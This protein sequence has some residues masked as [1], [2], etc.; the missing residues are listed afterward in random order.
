MHGHVAASVCA[1]ACVRAYSDKFQEALAKCQSLGMNLAVP[2]TIAEQ[3]FLVNSHALNL[4]SYDPRIWVG[5][6]DAET[7]GEL[8]M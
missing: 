2:T 6:T 7:N 4:T 8:L 1:C 5:L 3:D